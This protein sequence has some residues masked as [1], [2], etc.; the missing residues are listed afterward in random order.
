MSGLRFINQKGTFVFGGTTMSDM[1]LKDQTSSPSRSVNRSGVVYTPR[2]D[3][4]ETDEAVIL[5]GDVPGVSADSIDIQFEN[6][7][8]TIWGRVPRRNAGGKFWA[9]EYGVGDYY[10]T[11]VL[12]D[13]VDPAAI[14]ADLKDGVLT[15]RLTKRADARPMRVAVRAR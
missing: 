4:F 11:F 7:E 5:S 12:G 9:S 2:F 10:R 14:D 1:I 6:K 13:S 8:L 15:V 3:V